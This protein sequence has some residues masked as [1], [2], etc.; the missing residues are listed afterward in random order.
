[1]PKPVDVS[2]AAHA[3]LKAWYSQR[4]NFALMGEFSA[5]KSTLLNV[6]LG[7]QI[8]PARV[9][10]TT[11]PVIWMTYGPPAAFGLT[12]DG[13][14]HPLD[15]ATP[16][17]ETWD[18]YLVVRMCSEAP[19]LKASDVIDTPGL[20]DPRLSAEALRFLRP[21]LDFVI[22]CTAAGQAWRQSEKAAWKAMPDALKSDAILAVTGA[23][24]LGSDAKLEKVLTRLN[25]EA[26]P[27][28]RDVRPIASKVALTASVDGKLTDPDLWQES[29]AHALIKT[30]KRSIKS[31]TKAC[32]ARE[33]LA[34]PKDTSETRAPETG[35]DQICKSVPPKDREPAHEAMR[36]TADTLTKTKLVDTIKQLRRAVLDG[37]DRDEAHAR[38]LEQCLTIDAATPRDWDR[39]LTQVEQDIEDFST[40]AW[41][42]LAQRAS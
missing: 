3:R 39:V 28:F 30:I 33:T 40:G 32:A 24:K 8:I 4:P 27:L 15:G 7:R 13:A 23:D 5:G 22:W 31:A 26:G 1:M 12:A 17:P 19:L 20:S 34:D 38:V 29:G 16:D 2:D 18:D 25:G 6:L 21:Y 35:A 14:L 10:A 41:C 37:R 42:D 9:T 36:H 11:L